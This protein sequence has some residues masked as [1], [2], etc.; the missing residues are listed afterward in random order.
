LIRGTDPIVT[1]FLADFTG[2]RGERGEGPGEGFNH[3]FPLPFG[4]ECAAYC[5]ELRKGAEI[6]DGFD[7]AYLVVR[8]AHDVIWMVYC[9]G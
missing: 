3:N 6:I 4:T 8:Y 5:S 7:P 2:T 1:I 9:L